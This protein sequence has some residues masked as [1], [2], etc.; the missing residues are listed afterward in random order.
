[1]SRTS[2]RLEL[3]LTNPHLIEAETIPVPHYLVFPPA[4]STSVRCLRCCTLPKGQLFNP[5][6]EDLNRIF[7]EQRIMADDH[8]FFDVGLGDQ[9]PIERILVMPWK[10][11]QHQDV[12]QAYR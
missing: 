5:L 4:A 10:V 2:H 6:P 8:S 12:R 7:F 11:L 1:M 3:S 9:Q